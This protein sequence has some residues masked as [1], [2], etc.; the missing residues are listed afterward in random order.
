MSRNEV[1]QKVGRHIEPGL[2][3]RATF[4]HFFPLQYRVAVLL[5]FT[6]LQ[7]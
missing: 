4:A 2:L 1:L 7:S 5:I 3:R 6:Q